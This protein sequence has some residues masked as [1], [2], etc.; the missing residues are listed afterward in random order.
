MV[1]IGDNPR[2]TAGLYEFGGSSSE[3]RPMAFAS[4][5]NIWI[6]KDGGK[7][8]SLLDDVNNLVSTLVHEN[9]HKIAKHG[10]DGDRTSKIDAE[11]VAY[12]AQVSHKSYTK[13]TKDFQYQIVGG[14]ASYLMDSK[15][16]YESISNRVSEFNKLLPKGSH[17]K[18]DFK[19]NFQSFEIKIKEIKEIKER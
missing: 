16:G 14:Y 6:N 19:P 15:A 10:E 3:K 7:I 18:L 12:S 1:P 8:A 9:A 2:G 4:G 5:G 13:T 17:Y 11:K